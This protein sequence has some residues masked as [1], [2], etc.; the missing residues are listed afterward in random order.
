MKI[1]SYYTPLYS[2]VAANLVKSLVKLG[3]IEY[4]VEE[5]P[6]LGSWARNTQYKANFILEKLEQNTSV[7]WTDADSMLYS[8]PSLFDTI[9]CD[10]AFFFFRDDKWKLPITSKLS[11]AVADRDGYLQSGTMYFNNTPKTIELL[12]KWIKL[13]EEDN[14]QWDQHTLQ[15]ALGEIKDINICNLPPEY[16]WIDGVSREYFGD[17]KPVFEHF[18]ASR[19]YKKKLL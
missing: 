18:Q 11:Q 13:N 19:I 17:I 1:V 4:E 14:T 15:M 10:V 12:N 8:Y 16:A 6:Q 9:D 5:R 2:M 3:N 7:V